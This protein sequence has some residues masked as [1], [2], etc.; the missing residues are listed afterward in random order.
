MESILSFLHQYLG[1][2]LKVAGFVILNLILIESLLSVDNAA[3]LATMVR[4]LPI[5]QRKKAL[6]IGIILAYIFRGAC[7]IFASVLMKI[8]WLKLFGGAYLL[9]I[10]INF[11]FKKY[12]G[13]PAIEEPHTTKKRLKF[14]S[15]FMSTVLMVELMDLTFS[16]DNVFAAVAFTDNIVLVCIGVFIGIIA[17]RIVAGYFV[18]LME[19]FPFL[20]TIA[21]VIIGL[22]GVK[23]CLSYFAPYM[24]KEASELIDGH[25]TDLYFSIITVS[26]F[27][28]PILSSWLF[29][30]PKKH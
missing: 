10:F 15:P 24:G 1:P 27:G 19:L 30:F 4:D 28:L 6:R 11:F 26:I 9:Y 5:K 16:I 22:L 3:V 17:M 20:D 23:L 12:R 2:D 7:L 18:K 14:L 13:K 29:N 25:K 8:S 21:F